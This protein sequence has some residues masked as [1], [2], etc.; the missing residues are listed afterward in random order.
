MGVQELIDAIPS[1]ASGDPPEGDLLRTELITG[2]VGFIPGD[3]PVTLNVLQIDPADAELGGIRQAY[4]YGADAGTFV[5]DPLDNITA[6][7][8]IFCLV[9]IGGYRYKRVGTPNIGSVKSRVVATPPDPNDVDPELRPAYGDAYLYLTGTWGTEGI[10]VNSIAVWSSLDAGSWQEIEPKFGPPLYVEDEDGFIRWTGDDGWKNG[11]GSGAHEDDTIPLSAIAGLA[12]SLTIRVQNQTTNTPPASPAIGED[13]IIGP[14]PT[15]DWAGQAGKVARC[16]TVEVFA[17]YTPQV[18]DVVHDLG[19]GIKVQWNGTAWISDA[20]AIIG[21]TPPI[22]TQGTGNTATTG[23]S[24]IAYSNTSPPTTATG[25]RRN[26]N[27]TQNY[28]AK[29]SGA[30]LLVRWRGLITISGF[31]GQYIAGLLRD[32]ETNAIAWDA[33]DFTTVNIDLKSLEWLVTAPDTAAHIYKFAVWITDG[34]AN[35]SAFAHRLF[36]IQEIG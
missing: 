8:L 14:L 5:Y 35:V 10:A 1:E 18:G 34:A 11:V 4:V 17:I 20:G 26:D 25:F 23:S 31:S 9:L 13:Y 21:M 6:Q 15:D 33:I 16:E 36:D 19:T 29:R 30:S 2:F 7:D 27:I 12:A 22:F 32:S 24:N 3:T 28:T